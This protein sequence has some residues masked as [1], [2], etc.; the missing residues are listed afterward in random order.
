M[1]SKNAF[2]DVNVI[3]LHY[4]GKNPFTSNYISS[5]VYSSNIENNY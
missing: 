2:E 5:L 3:N 4:K 1:R